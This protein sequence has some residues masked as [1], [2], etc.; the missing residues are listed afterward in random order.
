MHRIIVRH[1]LCTNHTFSCPIKAYSNT[2]GIALFSL[3]VATIGFNELIYNTA[4]GPLSVQLRAIACVSITIACWRYA[5]NETTLKTLIKLPGWRKTT[6]NCRVMGSVWVL[7]FFLPIQDPYIYL[8]HFP[9]THIQPVSR[10]Q[11]LL[12]NAH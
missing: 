9:G 7:F 10:L 2:V 3:V 1:V 5:L 6:H 12:S 11:L 8:T 4:N